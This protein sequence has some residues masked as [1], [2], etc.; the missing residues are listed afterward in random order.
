M[1]KIID[2]LTE[3]FRSGLQK[4]M[5]NYVAPLTKNPPKTIR[6]LRKQQLFIEFTRSRGDG[7]IDDLFYDYRRNE[8]SNRMYN[9]PHNNP[10]DSDDFSDYSEIMDDYDESLF[11]KFIV[12][13]MI[14]RLNDAEYNIASNI[15]A[16]KL[17]VYR[18]MKVGEDYL[19]HITM[20]GKRLGIYWTIDKELAE[21]YSGHGGV[22]HPTKYPGDS[23]VVVIETEIHENY[24][25]WERT[26]FARIDYEYGDQEEEITLFKG[27]PIKILYLYDKDT[28]EDFD[29]SVIKDKTFYA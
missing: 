23:M 11:V 25:D 16:G 4:F 8:P 20:Q 7:I 13:E 26:L 27:T 28:G 5:S 1:K 24:I 14:D 6:E 15:E 2:Y 29:I 9:R 3:D 22:N 10:E 21:V 18:A 19:S 17:R 12:G